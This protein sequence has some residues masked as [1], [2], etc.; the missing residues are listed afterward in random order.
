M[1]EYNSAIPGAHYNQVVNVFSDKTILRGW[2]IRDVKENNIKESI[3]NLGDD[4]PNYTSVEY[5][6]QMNKLF[7][8]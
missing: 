8:E 5:S 1:D 2:F 6:K 3:I 7:S 4:V